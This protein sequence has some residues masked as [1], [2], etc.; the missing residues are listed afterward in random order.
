M[1]HKKTLER[2]VL[3]FFISVPIL[4]SLISTY[5]LISFFKVGNYFTISL[6]L[7]FTFEIGAIA[8]LLV[9]GFLQNINKTMLWSVFIILAFMQI[10]GNVFYSY[11]FIY[12]K[13]LEDPYWLETSISFFQYFGLEKNS[14]HMMISLLIGIPIPLISLF[15]LKSTYEYLNKID[16]NKIDL[17]KND[18]QA[19]LET[20][21]KTEKV[22]N[23]LKY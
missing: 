23:H 18:I 20:P 10:L 15:F 17:N 16:L 2:I 4:S 11:D 6:I 1:L 3:Y 7:A 5:H 14:I 21:N 13:L 19:N 8:S 12:I 22:V 9:L